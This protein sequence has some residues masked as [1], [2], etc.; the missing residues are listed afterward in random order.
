MGIPFAHAHIA[1]TAGGRAGVRATVTLALVAFALAIAPAGSAAKPTPPQPRDTVTATGNNLILDHFAATA[2]D[3][4]AASGPSGE[5]PQG[6]GS[7]AVL[8]FPISGPVSCLKVTD[9]VAVIEIDGPLIA[10]PGTLSIIIRLTDNGGNGQ[11]RFEWYPVLPEVGQDFDCETGAP[12]YFGG[13]LA[14]ARSCTMCR[15]AR[16]R[17]VTAGTG[18]GPTTG[19]RASASAS[20]S[21]ANRLDDLIGNPVVGLER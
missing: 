1:R 9:N 3:V 13:P 17:S 21:S 7:F 19:S 10:P 20:G 5:D 11:D 15:P 12:G 8:N 18:D 4:D 2:I 16:P 14:G 6:A